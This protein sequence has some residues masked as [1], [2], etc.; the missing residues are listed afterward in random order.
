MTDEQE[1]RFL[2]LRNEW[3]DLQFIQEL[4]GLDLRKE[5]RFQKHFQAWAEQ[6]GRATVLRE[7]S[8]V[9]RYRFET[10][11][12]SQKLLTRKWAALRLGMKDES[13]N[14]LLNH[15]NGRDLVISYYPSA[16]PYQLVGEKIDNDI[17]EL[18]DEFRFR[19]F[20]DHNNFCRRMHHAIEQKFGVKIEPEFDVTSRFLSRQQQDWDYAHDWDAITLEPVSLQYQVWLDFGKPMNL[21]PDCC[22]KL[23]YVQERDQLKNYVAGTSEP[24]LP[25]ELVEK[26][27][28]A[29]VGS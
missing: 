4:Y 8:E 13:L 19:T 3:C 25:A 5:V 9:H 12:Q 29:A 27:H 14:E 17:L 28:N 7:G 22:S 15:L 18:F 11:L 2:M 10:F 1:R 20:A 24:D 21:R 23:F 26:V 16:E 6:R